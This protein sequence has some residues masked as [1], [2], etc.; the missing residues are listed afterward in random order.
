[1]NLRAETIENWAKAEK[2]SDKDLRPNSSRGH[3]GREATPID[4][5]RPLLAAQRD[6][7]L[8]LLAVKR[9]AVNRP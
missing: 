3:L 1:M 7:Y 6:S 5:P 8:V 9:V 4:V 2:L